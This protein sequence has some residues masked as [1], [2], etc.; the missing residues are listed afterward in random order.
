MMINLDVTD[1]QRSAVR[2]GEPVELVLGDLGDVVVLPK[3]VYEAL[4]DEREKTA[5]MKLNQ[6]ALAQWGRDNPY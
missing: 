4:I 1:E 3:D 5:W 2:R 6:K